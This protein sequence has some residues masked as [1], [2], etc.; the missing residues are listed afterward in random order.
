MSPMNWFFLFMY[1]NLAIYL[2]FIKFHFLSGFF[3]LA[4]SSVGV[5]SVSPMLFYI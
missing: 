5:T 3:I 4:K 1:F 2:T